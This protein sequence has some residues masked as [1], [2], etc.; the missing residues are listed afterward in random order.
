MLD[1]IL[2]NRKEWNAKKEEYEANLK[3]IEDAKAAKAAATAGKSEAHIRN[4]RN[5]RWLRMV[6]ILPICATAWHFL[7]RGINIDR[8]FSLTSLSI[9][10]CK[11]YERR[12]L[13]LQDVFG[14]LK[15]RHCNL[16][17][18]ILILI[19]TKKSQKTTRSEINKEK[20]LIWKERRKRMLSEENDNS[21]TTLWKT[22]LKNNVHGH[23]VSCVMVH[24]RLSNTFC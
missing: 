24:W 2:N 3:A 20:F 17:P 12:R 7:T 13:R 19:T 10:S 15:H 16:G 6:E 21:A 23:D 8:S 4:Y 1:G 22:S 18:I 5:L 9:S 11:Q 14:V